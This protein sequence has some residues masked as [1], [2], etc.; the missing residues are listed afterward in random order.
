MSTREQQQLDYLT[1]LIERQ[2]ILLS[3]VIRKAYQMSKEL[4]DLTVQVQKNADVEASAIILIQGIADAL[5]VAGTDPVKLQEL[6]TSLSASSDALAA[7]V[8]ANTP[9]A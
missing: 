8:A 3:I 7:A 6:Q 4:D 2:S 9:T 5:R 1:Q